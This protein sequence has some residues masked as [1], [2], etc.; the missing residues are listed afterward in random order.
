MFIP[1]RWICKGRHPQSR[2]KQPPGGQARNSSASESPAGI[3]GVWR[4]LR[5]GRLASFRFDLESGGQKSTHFQ[6]SPAPGHSYCGAYE[7]I[8]CL[9]RARGLTPP[10]WSRRRNWPVPSKAPFC[11]RGGQRGPRHGPQAVSVQAIVSRQGWVGDVFVFFLVRFFVLSK[12][13]RFVAHSPT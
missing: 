3:W 8:F 1:R 7:R 5:R 6:P 12:L 13:I 9:G 11:P 4:L 10:A 2:K